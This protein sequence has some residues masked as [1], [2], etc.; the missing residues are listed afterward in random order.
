MGGI[1]GYLEKIQTARFDP[2]LGPGVLRAWIQV[3][4]RLRPGFEQF[5]STV[6]FA[7][8]SVTSPFFRGQSSRFV[9][10]KDRS[11]Q[12]AARPPGRKSYN[13]EAS[14]KGRVGDQLVDGGSKEVR[15]GG[16]GGSG[17]EVG[18]PAGLPGYLL[19]AGDGPR[20]GGGRP[21]GGFRAPVHPRVFVREDGV[22]P[23]PGLQPRPTQ[24][25]IGPGGAERLGPVRADRVGRG[26]GPDRRAVPS[27]GRLIRRAASDFAL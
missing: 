27:G 17:R 14:M 13:L 26:F 6:G 7:N 18:L 12:N 25:A 5:G 1:V 4:A 2:K 9:A 24:D 21:S 22:V 11:R 19:D 16:I 15:R 10:M 8:S 20:R 3:S 23:R